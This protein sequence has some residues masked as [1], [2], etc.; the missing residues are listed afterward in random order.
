MRFNLKRR[1]LHRHV[2]THSQSFSLPQMKNQPAN[3]LTMG[4]PTCFL[5]C[6]NEFYQFRQAVVVFMWPGRMKIWSDLQVNKHRHIGKS[7]S[8]KFSSKRA[9]E[10]QLWQFSPGGSLHRCNVI[11]YKWGRHFALSCH[12]LTRG[13]ARRQRS[14]HAY[15]E[16]KQRL[17]LWE[18]KK[19]I[20]ITINIGFLKINLKPDRIRFESGSGPEPERLDLNLDSDLIKPNRYPPLQDKNTDK[21]TTVGRTSNSFTN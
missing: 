1:N 3:K 21:Q 10:L 4:R 16:K 6:T 17:D 8:R 18:S 15:N 7:K 11:V 12:T 20:W 13:R 2:S 5:S 9:R 14:S 19:I